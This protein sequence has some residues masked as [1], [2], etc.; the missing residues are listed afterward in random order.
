[1][2]KFPDYNEYMKKFKSMKLDIYSALYNNNK[3][4]EYWKYLGKANS[5]KWSHRLDEIITNKRIKPM[6]S[7]IKHSISKMLNF[8]K[9]IVEYPPLKNVQNSRFSCCW[10]LD[11]SDITFGRTVNWDI[12]IQYYEDEWFLVN[13]GSDGTDN[14]WYLCDGS[15]GL[16]KLISDKKLSSQ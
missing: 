10:F 5:P 15:E 1:M 11:K 13:I 2:G 8:K 14:F 12:C 6:T 7:D 3:D 16:G 9:K 4:N